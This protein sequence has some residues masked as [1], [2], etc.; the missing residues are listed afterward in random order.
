[1]YSG[2]ADMG[3]ARLQHYRDEVYLSEEYAT[4]LGRYTCLDENGKTLDTGK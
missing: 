1:M 4:S 2:M 3:G